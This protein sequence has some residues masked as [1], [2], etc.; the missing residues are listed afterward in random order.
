MSSKPLVKFEKIAEEHPYFL[1]PEEYPNWRE[2]FGNDH[3]LVFDIGF[4][5]GNFLLDMAVR[6]PEWNFIG[7]DFYH[8]GI[9]RLFM[10][11]DRHQLTN[12]RIVY[13]DA[14]EK[15]PFLFREGELSDVYINFPD[16]WPKKRHHKRR[17]VKPDMVRS[18]TGKLQAE[19]RLRVATDF[20]PYAMEIL[21]ILSAEPGL[22]NV[23]P[24]PG[25]TH[26]RE[27]TPR[28]KYEK[29]FLKAGKTIYYFD[30]IKPHPAGH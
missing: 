19:G 27:D 5:N 8:K 17:L 20:E 22:R 1:D 13:G 23:H 28:S 4:G 16:P 10:R 30:F 9:R 18:L 29:N 7:M 2:Q 25:Y 3:P 24:A 15:V 26:Q 14:R 21:E 12:I 6:H 11:L